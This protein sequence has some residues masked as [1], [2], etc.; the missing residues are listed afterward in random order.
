FFDSETY[1]KITFYS[2]SFV[3]SGNDY[4]MLGNLTIKGI[5]K[6]VKLDVEYGGSGKDMEGNLKHGFEVTGKIN[7]K[8]FDMTYNAL[9]ETGG[10]TLGED[11]KLIANI[12]IAKSLE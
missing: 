10:L 8:E 1:P 4:K 11:I 7:R 5:T 12:Q 9:T 6:P 3:K 2:T